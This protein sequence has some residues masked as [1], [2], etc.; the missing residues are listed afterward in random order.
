M[1]LYLAYILTVKLANLEPCQKF[2]PTQEILQS[3]KKQLQ[4][5]IKFIVV[6]INISCHLLSLRLLH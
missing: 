3:S 1:A 2:E 5:A 4:S 6:K